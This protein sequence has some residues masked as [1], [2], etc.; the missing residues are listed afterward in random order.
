MKFPQG[1]YDV[2]YAD[3]AWSY[4]NKRTGGS[5]ESGSDQKYNTMTLEEICALPVPDISAKDSVLFLWCTTP[6]KE[7][8][9]ET[10][11]A[12]GFKYK[13]TIYW[14]KIMSLGMGFW[15]RGQVEELLLGV[16]GKVKAFRLQEA[17]FIQAKALRHSEKPEEF[18]QLIERAT[19]KMPSQ[20]RLELFARKRAD[21]WDSWGDELC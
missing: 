10:M 3:P 20:K 16:R 2:I 6:L 21:G 5:M 17:N 8:G 1:K 4:R 13:T 7:Y 18:R 9:L 11:R 15:F 14:R 12:W 19:A